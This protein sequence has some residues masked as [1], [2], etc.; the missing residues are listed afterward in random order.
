VKKLNVLVVLCV[1][2]IGLDH[3]WHRVG[4][5]AQGGQ[6]G[7]GKGGQLGASNGDVNGSGAIDISDAVY[8]LS[9]LF[10]GGS[11][12]VALAQ[13][14]GGLM[15]PPVG[16]GTSSPREALEVMGNIRS[17]GKVLAHAFSSLS[18]LIF[19]AP[20]GTERARITDNGD[21][22]IATTT[23]RGR[24][25]IGDRFVFHDGVTKEISRN[26]YVSGVQSKRIV[27]D[28]AA[29]IYFDDTG[30]IGLQVAA[31]GAADSVIAWDPGLHVASGGAVRIG[32]EKIVAG[33]H[34]DAKLFV[35]GK[36]VAREAVV[37][38][39]NWAD[40][41]FADDYPL[42]SLRDVEKTV[43]EEKRL[44]GMPSAKQVREEGGIQLGAT[45]V[46]LLEKV[47]E[48]TLYAIQLQKKNDELERR[49]SALEEASS[50]R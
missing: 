26:A 33:P 16:I 24:L 40:H 46:K 21:L 14:D 41:V 32:K 1:V 10:S 42:P 17:N 45:Q 50:R 8:L 19:E 12:P 47:E 15:S 23:P 49:L 25:Q 5:G 27:A 11:A 38:I 48:L 43:R 7:Q 3:A 37:T 28:E 29:S 39:A 9:W 2:L 18:P 4:L 6:G 30:G 31:T 20:S 13:G 35:D 22:G 34:T 36:I 44:P